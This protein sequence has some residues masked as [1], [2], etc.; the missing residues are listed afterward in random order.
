MATNIATR[1]HGNGI[2]EGHSFNRLVLRGW[3]F[4]MG[5]NWFGVW[6]CICGTFCVARVPDVLRGAQKSCG[7][8]RREQ[9]SIAGRCSITHGETGSRL[10]N[11]WRGMLRRCY[12]PN[13]DSYRYYGQRGV[14]VCDE[15]HRYE[16]FAEWA[17]ANG[18]ND[19]LTI[20]RFPD[21][22]GNYTPT[23]CRWATH[24]QQAINRDRTITIEQEGGAIPLISVSGDDHNRL[25]QRLYRGYSSDEL[26][27]VPKG[28]RRSQCNGERAAGAK[29]TDD[30]V[31]AIRERYRGRGTGPRM[32]DLA[33][34]YGCSVSLISLI[35]LG[36][37]RK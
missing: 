36:R 6:E 31:A 35:I 24:S 17:R 27:A 10:Y 15:W 37:V 16:P 30:Q 32:R 4:R 29:L 18:Y 8:H 23:N 3:Q 33:S 7:C 34:E 2:S 9:T 26:F 12:E 13:I 5:D 20:D 21:R 25:K 11:I 19:D 1:E 22:H 28:R 14:V